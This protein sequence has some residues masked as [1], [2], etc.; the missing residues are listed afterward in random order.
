MNRRLLLSSMA[1]MAASPVLAQT[2]PSQAPSPAGNEPNRPQANLSP[3]QQ[4]HIK[5]TLTVGSLSLMLSRIAQ[6]KVTFSPLKQFAEFEIAE[7][8]TAADVLKAIKTNAAPNGSIPTPS[9][10]EVMQNLDEAGKK[11]VQKLRDMKDGH[12]FDMEYVRQEIEGH[13]KLLAFQEA[14]LKAP[15]NLDETNFAKMAQT[16]IHEHL[17]LLDGMQKLGAQ[18]QTKGQAATKAAP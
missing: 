8:Q 11:A 18:A 13:Q 15:D 7:Q 16:M 6:K 10:A 14:Y 5:D 3:A 4:K 17:T 12:D 9:D 1:V 2:N